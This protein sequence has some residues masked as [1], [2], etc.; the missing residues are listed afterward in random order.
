MKGDFSRDTFDATKHFSRVLMQQGRVQL[1]AD[2]NEQAAILLHYMRALAADLIGRHGGPQDNLGFGIVDITKLSAAE[3]TRLE[4][5]K[6]LPLPPGDFL[7]GIGH[8][9]VDGVLCENEDY[10][11]YGTQ[12]DYSL[13]DEKQPKNLSGDYLV[14]LDV[15]E[16]HLTYL[17]VE[18][19]DGSVISPREVALNGPDTAT[20]AQ[21]VWQI[22]TKASQI[23]ADKAKDYNT[24]LKELGAE[25][26]PETGLLMARAIQPSSAP[27]DP[28]TIPPDARYRGAENQLY[29]VEVHLG[30]TA[31]NAPKAT[32]KWSRENGSVIFPIRPLAGAKVTLEA[33]GRDTRQGLQPGDWVEIVDDD[34][35]LQNRAEP[36]LQVDAI[37]YDDNVVTLATAPDSPVGQDPTKHPLLRRW[38]QRASDASTPT[39]DGL[40]IIEGDKEKNWI[41]LEDGI[42]IQF[43]IGGTYRTGDYWLIP[44]RTATGDVEWPGPAG[45]PAALG[46]RGV[47]H[48]YAPLWIISVGANGAIKVDSANDLRRM[49]KPLWTLT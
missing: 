11:G 16:R 9:Y 20:R 26:R 19:T 36:L 43:Q 6:I 25:I 45:A 40:A 23:T 30:G 33:L 49:F 42:Q 2:W 35:T 8:Y 21:V 12:T 5:L 13:P 41:E 15:W 29:R 44:A 3:Q 47:M 27:N 37:D 14:Y 17:E 39:E 34:Y 28:C 22:K 24:F 4:K 46:P 48:H 31:A 10:V 38:D 1:D 18:D 7:I 32:F